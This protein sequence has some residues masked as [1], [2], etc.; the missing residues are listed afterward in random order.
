MTVQKS[1]RSAFKNVAYVAGEKR[2]VAG[3][4]MGEFVIV[5]VDAHGS[6]DQS[7]AN[8]EA[9]EDAMHFGKALAQTIRELQWAQDKC[10][11]CS[12]TMGKQNP[13]EGRNVL[14]FWISHVD[15]EALVV[16]ENVEVHH[17]DEGREDVFSPR[18]GVVSN[19]ENGRRRHLGLCFQLHIGA[20]GEG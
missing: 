5:H 13:L 19:I 15:E 8:I 12:Q 10:A 6:A 16:P 4:Q 11:G 14:P 17:G 3:V 1:Q 18:P 7:A 9:P 2:G 20:S